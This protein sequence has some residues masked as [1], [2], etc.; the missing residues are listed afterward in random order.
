MIIK[1]ATSIAQCFQRALTLVKQM[2]DEDE[3]PYCWFRGVNHRK[4]KLEPGSYR[5]GREKYSEEQAMITFAQEAVAFGDVG[6]VDSWDSYYLAQHHGVPTRLL[7]WTE[8]FSAALF[9]ALDGAKKGDKPCVWVLRP[10]LVNQNTIQWKGIIAPENYPKDMKPWLPR[11]IGTAK[12]EFSKCGKYR[13]DNSNPV[14]IYA[15]RSNARIAAQHGAFTLH[16]HN[17]KPL[18]EQ[19]I[20]NMPQ[21]K[22]IIGRV[23][24]DRIDVE[25]ARYHLSV[26]GIRRSSIYPDIDNYVKQLGETYWPDNGTYKSTGIKNPKKNATKGTSVPRVAKKKK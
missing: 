2:G 9:F 24:L 21:A 20:K 25:E 19:I 6:S 8:S 12:S 5:K 7:D 1:K 26:L 14:A 17:R 11:F 4:Y 3:P 15:K 23:E 16:G 22:K 13:Y 18:C 10:D